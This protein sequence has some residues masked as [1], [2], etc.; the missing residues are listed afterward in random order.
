MDIDTLRADHLGCYGYCRDT[1]PNVDRIA[2]QGV[3]F[4][5]CYISDAPCLP[6]RASLFTG[7]FGIHTG[8]VNHGGTAA[9]IRIV[10]PERQFRLQ[11]EFN[12]WM[13]A[14]RKA[15]LYTVSVSPFAER[16]SAWWF[17]H[18]FREMYNTGKGGGEIASEVT[19]YALEWLKK[20]A[21][22]D[23]WF[24]HVNVWDPHTSYRTP[25]E[26]GNRFEGQPY[27]Q[28]LT[29]AVIQRD[30]NSYGP[31]SA[32]D[33]GAWG[34]R[35]DN[36]P[37]APSQIRNLSDYRRWMDGYDMGIWFADMHFGLLLNELERQG[38]LD[39][40]AVIISSD[41]SENQGELNVYGD[42]HTADL[43]TAR[44]PLV[45]RWPGLPGGRAD[46]A[47]HYAT[48]MAATVIELVGGEVPR[49]WDG[50]SF[51]PALRE[52]RGQGREFTVSGNCAWTCQRA[53]RW[54]DWNLL[55][56]YHD[57]LKDLA[58]VMLFN[59][60]EDP[61]LT[62]ELS[63]ERPDVANEGLAKL[64]QWTAEMMGAS[65]SD[66]DPMWNV[67]REGGPY[68]TRGRLKSY[69]DHLRQTGRAHHA[70]ALLARHAHWMW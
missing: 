5:S 62:R 50:R 26:Y 16:H 48:D 11:P 33:L 12:S 43:N 8:V 55:R 65:R 3:R 28:W 64:E 49:I 37:R 35:Q 36:M 68:H 46:A 21:K 10:G 4:D 17:Y 31:H 19:P 14:L 34:P 60:A 63:R 47:L 2:A 20:H 24:L 7:R 27:D 1:S 6:S 42:H 58:P 38:V 54:G 23:N 22:E 53:V 67:I 32:Q 56:T 30:F 39:E 18:G 15:G 57:G 45:I 59:V 61:H 66:V 25:M 70:D 52:G 69:C 29:E 13:A 51:A 41:H 9:D 44:V 40:T